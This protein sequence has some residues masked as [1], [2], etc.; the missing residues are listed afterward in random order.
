M[1]YQ[2]LRKKLRDNGFINHEISVIHRQYLLV[3]AL[4][5]P[6]TD[7]V[8]DRDHG[9]LIHQRSA[10]ILDRHIGRNI[11][12]DVERDIAFEVPRGQVH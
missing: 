11:A 2:E 4:G 5:V 6:D 8:F 1:T 3:K 9:L 12:I 10:K 7:I